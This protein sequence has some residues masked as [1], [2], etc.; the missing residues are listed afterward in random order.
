[1]VTDTQHPVRGQL[2]L[3]A[4]EAQVLSAGHMSRP[5]VRIPWSPQPTIRKTQTGVSIMLQVPVGNRGP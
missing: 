5:G 4:P 3:W 2:R 1:M